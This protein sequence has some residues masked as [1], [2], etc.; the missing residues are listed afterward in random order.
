MIIGL[1]L[2]GIMIGSIVYANLTKDGMLSDGI[3]AVLIIGTFVA[4]ILSALGIGYN[5]KS[6]YIYA[7]IEAFEDVK[8]MYQDS[9]TS[10][11][12]AVVRLDKQALGVE[13]I[14]ALVDIGIS[15]ENLKHS[16]LTASRIKE[17]RDYQRRIMETKYY[18]RRVA[19]NWFLCMFVAKPPKSLF[20]D[21]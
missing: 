12:D 21:D 10:T 2:L 6:L 20:D 16:S 15:V 7:K 13:Q 4:I 14:A 19:S 3:C 5:I 8:Q 11:A 17:A 1:V 9:I 18:Y